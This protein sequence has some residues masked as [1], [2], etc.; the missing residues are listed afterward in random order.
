MRLGGGWGGAVCD[1]STTHTHAHAHAHAHAGSGQ[2]QPGA[3][4]AAACSRRWARASTAPPG[5]AAQAVLSLGVAPE[6]VIF[7]HPCKRLADLRYAAG[8]GVGLHDVRHG[9]ELAK[10]AALVP[11][12]RPRAA[13]ALRRP[14]GALLGRGRAA[15]GCARLRQRP[16]PLAC[17]RGSRRL[18]PEVPLCPAPPPP[19][20]ACRWASS[21]A[22]TPRT[23]PRCS[24][25][26]AGWACAWWAPPSTWAAAASN[27][28]RV[29]TP[30]SRRRARVFDGGRRRGP[31][32]DAA[33]HRRRLHGAL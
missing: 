30:R 33:G 8:A 27:L 14:R 4:S 32:D 19:R 1:P 6:R 18:H 11:R 25:P 5:G 2:V 15:W 23:R 29:S 17:T 24:R 16:G 7:A 28:R 3:R 20:R 22:P 10:I 9:G 21:T 13:P 26:P 12:R 31:R